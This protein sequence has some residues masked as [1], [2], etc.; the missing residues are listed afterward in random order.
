MRFPDR[1]L[2]RDRQFWL[3]LYHL[4]KVLL[5][6]SAGII[7]LCYLLL[8]RFISSTTAWQG[9]KEEPSA[10]GEAWPEPALGDAQGHQISDHRGPVLLLVGMLPN[11]RSPPGASSSSSTRC[12]SAKS[13]SCA[14]CTLFPCERVPGALNS[15]LNPILF[16]ASY[17][18]SSRKRSR[19]YCMTASPSL[20]SMRPFTATT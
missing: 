20:T 9:P 1:L 17:A 2:G 18:A 10:A 19:T 3:G 5:P 16:T 13:T 14:R 11:Q 8:V 6:A 4:Q 15:C 7:S 12:P